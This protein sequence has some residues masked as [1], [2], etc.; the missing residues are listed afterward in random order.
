MAMLT[1]ND[2]FTNQQF[3]EEIPYGAIKEKLNN[4]IYKSQSLSDKIYRLSYQNKD[5]SKLIEE[6]NYIDKEID[7]MLFCYPNIENY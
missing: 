4:L 5:V 7:N 3:D 1:P 2:L 6:K